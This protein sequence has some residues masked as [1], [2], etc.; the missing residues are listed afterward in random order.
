[1][2]GCGTV[3]PFNGEHRFLSNFWPARVVLDG[4]E[5]PTT[6]HAYQA[7]KTMDH[8]RRRMIRS[9]PTPGHAKRQ[10]R[11]LT[12]RPDW[13]RVKLSVMEDLLRQ[14][15]AKEPLRSQ[16]LATYPWDLVEFNTW[17]DTFWGVCN[18]KGT[19]H[20]GRLLM[21]VRDGLRAQQSA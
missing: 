2:Q 8:G 17:G 4:L 16:L 18:G 20:L 7:A 13:E 3:G 21:K 14:K 11:N 19:N 1:M 10:G 9:L 6:E 5:Y 15:F 12:L